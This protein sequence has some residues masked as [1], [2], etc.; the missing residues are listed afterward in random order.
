[1]RSIYLWGDGRWEHFS[2]F[3]PHSISESPD[4][5]SPITCPTNDDST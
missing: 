2:T 3:F 5:T 4:F 1:M